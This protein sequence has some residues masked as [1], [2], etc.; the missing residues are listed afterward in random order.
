MKF[1]RRT[2]G[3]FVEFQE[4]RELSS[5]EFQALEEPFVEDGP[6]VSA[7]EVCLGAAEPVLN[8]V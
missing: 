8:E 5:R 4:L 7:P 1:G 6:T 3:P 2:F